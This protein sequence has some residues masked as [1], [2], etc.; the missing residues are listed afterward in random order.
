MGSIAFSSNRNGSYDVF[1][2]SV[3]GGRPKRLTF[4]SGSEAVSGWTPDGK[5]VIYSSNRGDEFPA[6]PDLYKIDVNGG[7][8][9]HITTTEAR[10]GAMSPD[11]TKIA[12]VRGPGFSFRKGYRGSANDDIWVSN[13][14]GSAPSA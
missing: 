6:R 1:V 13:A 11:G 12:Y 9:Q 3:L 8:E 10:Q 5:E 2:V 7:R 14:D 4:D